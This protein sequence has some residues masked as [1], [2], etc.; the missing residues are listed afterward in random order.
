MN[1]T[2]KAIFLSI[3]TVRMSLAERDSY[4]Y[5]SQLD[6]EVWP[7]CCNLVFERSR[8]N[9]LKHQRT[10]ITG[11]KNGDTENKLYITTA[12]QQSKYFCKSLQVF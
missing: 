5:H 12:Q 9:L 4:M 6:F 11:E 8:E 3:K 7:S 2:S 10:V 1:L